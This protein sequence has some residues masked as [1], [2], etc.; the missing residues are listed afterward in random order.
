MRAGGKGGA[1]EPFG[2][3]RYSAQ[4]RRLSP[5]KPIRPVC[6]G[7]PQFAGACL[8]VGV[9]VGPNDQEA[10]TAAVQGRSPPLLLEIEVREMICPTAI[11]TIE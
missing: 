5:I 1:G 6:Q 2:D 8:G 7:V 4:K 10:L 9:G 3:T 11:R